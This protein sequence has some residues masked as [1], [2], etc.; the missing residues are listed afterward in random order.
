MAKDSLAAGAKSATF[1]PP[2][3]SEKRWREIWAD[4]DEIAVEE[5]SKF[6]K[7]QSKQKRS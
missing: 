5:K 6:R 7:P 3:V 1:L 2:K 4:E